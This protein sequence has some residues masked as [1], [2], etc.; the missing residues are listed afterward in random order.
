MIYLYRFCQLL[1]SLL[2][3]LIWLVSSSLPFLKKRWD[4]EQ[5]NLL[6]NN[7]FF[8]SF[9]RDDL[10]AE[11]VYEVSSEGEW[12]QAWPF[13][14]A[15]L[16]DGLRVE[17]LYASDSL[18][19]RVQLSLAGLNPENIRFFR[20]PVLSFFPFAFGPF[21]NI[22]Y[23]CT[24]REL[25]LCRYDF[26][27]ELMLYGFKA[28]RFLLLTASLKSKQ[29]L[30][31][32]EGTLP[33]FF[34]RSQYSAFER[35]LLASAKEQPRF[36]S[37][38]LKAHLWT[39]EA[40]GLQISLRLKNA[41]QT[42]TQR[43]CD[44]LCFALEK[45]S[46]S[47]RLIFGSAWEEDLASLKSLPQQQ[48]KS[49]AIVIAPHQ[50][51]KEAISDLQIS[52]GPS[53]QHFLF[54]GTQTRAEISAALERGELIWVTMRGLLLEL[55]SLFS[56]AFVGGGFGRSVHSVLE[57]FLAGCTV[58]AGPKIYRST[59]AEFIT[60]QRPEALQILESPSDF[61]FVRDQVMKFNLAVPRSITYYE[62]IFEKEREEFQKARLFFL[63]HYTGEQEIG[64]SR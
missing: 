60:T 23:W 26:Y 61:A 28:E 29:A 51:A 1:R 19:K 6:E 25:V 43:N 62:N 2:A 30:L 52:L 45:F 53:F 63:G 17:L 33:H 10:K 31:A 35:I 15:D 27:P 4:F 58:F 49:M 16:S 3:P 44:A 12:E 24:G 21:Q 5:K 9:S 13:V 20:L 11:R 59:E 57:P 46:L 37:L 47:H 32:K 42:L 8:L 36:G 22:K 56:L 18:E 41:Q 55:Y 40:R 38:D 7:P 64:G 14:L 50:L 39:F 48:R 34:L 54:D